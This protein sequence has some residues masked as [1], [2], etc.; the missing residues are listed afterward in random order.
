MRPLSWLTDKGSVAR[1]MTKGGR[2]YLKGEYQKAAEEY[3]KVVLVDPT[4]CFA[5][6]E[7]GRA[8]ARAGRLQQAVA[9][10]ENVLRMNPPLPMVASEAAYNCALAYEKMEKYD[11]SLEFYSRTIDLDPKQSAAWCNKGSVLVKLCE[12][13][14]ANECF[15]EALRLD[16]R[17]VIAYFN[18]A[19]VNQK[20][21]NYDQ[22]IND[23]KNFLDL[24]P[25]THPNYSEAQQALDQLVAR[26]AQK[27]GEPAQ[28]AHVRFVQPGAASGSVQPKHPEHYEIMSNT[29][30]GSKHELVLQQ[31]AAVGPVVSLSYKWNEDID[32]QEADNLDS[33]ARAF[34]ACAVYDA[35]TRAGLSCR[36]GPPFGKR[37]S[38][39]I[40]NEQIPYSLIQAGFDTDEK[41]CWMHVGPIMVKGGMPMGRELTAGKLAEG[42]ASWFCQITV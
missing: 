34:I 4:N 25:R 12:W 31:A 26:M 17:D 11:R 22:V 3:S 9:D 28:E 1:A 8:Y 40:A 24:A 10:F 30:A 33:R 14:K 32:H 38:W 23:L 29:T 27:R 36:I 13:K 7:R 2:L 5:Y 15:T 19:I 41:V 6:N 18:R 21:Q 35:A 39:L 20:L 16:P 37:P 42:F